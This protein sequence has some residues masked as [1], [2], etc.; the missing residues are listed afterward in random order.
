M[1]PATLGQRQGCDTRDIFRACFERA[2]A[3]RGTRLVTDWLAVY[4]R[5]L[6]NV[7]TAID[8]A[9]STEDH[10]PIAV[11]LCA[12]S[13]AMMFDLSLVGEGRRRAEQ[14]L[15]AIHAGVQVPPRRRDAGARGPAGNPNLH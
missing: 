3:E 1:K 13:I 5:E 8:W 6:D 14:A 2:E 7:R 12:D 4:A 11:E 15:S 10:A 9:F